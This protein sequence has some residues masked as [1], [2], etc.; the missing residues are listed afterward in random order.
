M[1]ED[2]RLRRI[3]PLKPLTPAEERRRKQAKL[4]NDLY[5]AEDVLE[6]SFRNLGL[7]SRRI[8]GLPARQH[9]RGQGEPQPW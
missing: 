6:G 2:F 3:G 9:R 7:V 8:Q 1:G 4:A 5:D